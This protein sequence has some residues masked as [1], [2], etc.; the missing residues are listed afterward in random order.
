MN[1]HIESIVNTE[2]FSNIKHDELDPMLHCLSYTISY[3]DKGDFIF[4]ESEEIKS[5]G[6]LLEGSVDMIKEDFWGNRTTLMRIKTGETFGETFA[7]STDT[8]ST[9]SFCASSKATVL[10]LPFNRVMHSCTMCCGFHHRLIE[11]MV[12]IIAKKNKELMQKV[13][14]ISKKTLRD[15]IMAYLSVYAECQGTPYFEIPLGRIE[16]AEYLC[17]DRSALTRELSNMQADGIIDYDRNMFR[18]L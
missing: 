17:A 18:L 6:I 14:I 10:F 7:C 16:L 5:I 11:N 9:V 8:T 2:L 13:E 1:K 15:K 4:L 3:Y 12:L